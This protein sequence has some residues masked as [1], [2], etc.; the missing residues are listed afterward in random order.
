MRRASDLRRVKVEF[1]IALRFGNLK[2]NLSHV[3]PKALQGTLEEEQSSHKKKIPTQ[4]VSKT[5]R[6]L[7][8]RGIKMLSEKLMEY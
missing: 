1:Q 4:N 3:M 8:Q 5:F 7:F 2:I 6:I